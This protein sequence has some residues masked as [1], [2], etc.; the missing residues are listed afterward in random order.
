MSAKI[1]LTGGTGYIGGDVLYTIVHTHPE[2]DISALVRDSTK[3]AL[4]AKQ[5][6]QLRLVYGTLDDTQLLAKEAAAA[7]IVVHCAHADHVASAEALIKGLTGKPSGKGF[8]IHTGGSG[9]LCADDLE[10]GRYGEPSDQV[11]DDWDGL[12]VVTSLPDSAPHRIVDKVVLAGAS[13]ALKTAIVCPPTIYGLGRGPG[14]HR[15]IQAYSMTRTTLKRGKGVR[16]GKGLNN[17]TMVHVHDLSGLFLTLVE[18]AA[19]GGGKAAWGAEGYYFAENGEFLWGEVSEAIAKET[20]KRGFTKTDEVE[21]IGSEEADKEC[22]SGAFL[23]GT[24][25]RCKAIRA[26]KVLGWEPKGKSLWSE[27]PDIVDGEAKAVGMVKGHA[28]LAAGQ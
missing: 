11:Y 15:S 1:F 28:A 24:N 20:A 6:P 4:F 10:T 19:R 18:A 23:W 9:I 22:V 5:Y 25:S 7:D 16:V 14:N 27:I 13:D 3:G 8:L 21:S 2:Y 12:S 26:R 17:W